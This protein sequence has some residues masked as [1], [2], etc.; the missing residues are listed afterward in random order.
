MRIRDD[1]V[2]R[3]IADEWIVLPI[4]EATVSFKKMLVLN[5]TSALIWEAISSG[6]KE[7]E[8]LGKIIDVYDIDK[9]TARQDYLRIV[10]QLVENKII[11]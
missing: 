5:E 6:L 7:E 1:L 9:E 4:G 2:L 8:I 10:N 11:L 3:K